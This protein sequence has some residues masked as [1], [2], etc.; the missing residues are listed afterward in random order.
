MTNREGNLEAPTRHPVDWRNPAFYDDAGAREG[1][2][3]HLRHLPRLPPLREP[4]PGVPDAVRPGRRAPT[5][6]GRRRRQADYAKVVDQCY[7]CDLCYMTK[8]PYV[9]P[10]PWNVDFPHLMLRAKAVKFRKGEVQGARQAARRHR[11]ARSGSRASRWSCRWSTRST[12]LARRAQGDG[13][14]ARRGRRGVAAAVRERALSRWRASIDRMAGARRRAHARQGR[15]LLYLLHQ[16]QRARHRPRPRCKLL[17]HNEIPYASSRRKPAAACPS[18]S[19]AT[20]R[21]SNS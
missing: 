12:G 21:R 4:V 9:P 7:L 3:A 13:Q 16:L 17:E 10:H 1:A 14:G 18:S 2:G 20:S 19:W 6:R 5:R 15:D 11:R 8:C